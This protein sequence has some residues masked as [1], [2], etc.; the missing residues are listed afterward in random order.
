MVR[1]Q[2]CKVKSDLSISIKGDLWVYPCLPPHPIM[3][4]IQLLVWEGRNDGLC[5][6]IVWELQVLKCFHMKYRE[7]KKYIGKEV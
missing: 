6:H 5:Q 3:S 2:C 4:E 1:V 7:G